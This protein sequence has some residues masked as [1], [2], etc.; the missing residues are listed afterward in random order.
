[1][2]AGFK[3]KECWDP[4]ETKG[5]HASSHRDTSLQLWLED[6]LGRQEARRSL[7]PVLLVPC[8]STLFSPTPPRQVRESLGGKVNFFLGLGS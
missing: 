3:L 7:G 4:V 8:P 5:C 1:M 2:C 6:S